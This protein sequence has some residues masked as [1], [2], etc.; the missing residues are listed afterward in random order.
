MILTPD[1]DKNLLYTLVEFSYAEYGSALE[2]LCASK[3]IKSANLKMGY[4]EHALDEYRHTILIHKVLANQLKLN[5][6]LDF[7]KEYKFLPLNV[8]EK[9]YVDKKGFLVEKLHLKKFVEFVYTNEFLAKQSFDKLKLRIKDNE[10]LNVITSIMDDEQDHADSS[11]ETLDDIMADEYRHWGYAQ[12]Y[13][14][15]KYPES[16]LKRAFYR[17]K[18]KNK[19]RIAYLKNFKILNK[20]FDPFIFFLVIVF[21]NLVRFIKIPDL[22]ISKLTELKSSSI[23]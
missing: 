22:K 17:E 9:G 3:N 13:Y 6:E 15:K 16:K 10:S 4:I 1:S 2:M 8:V 12:K 19:L 18:L 21:G 14:E 7:I 11:I 23:I 5:P 20:I